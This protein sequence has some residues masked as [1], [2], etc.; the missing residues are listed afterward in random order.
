MSTHY[1]SRRM[2]VTFS[3]AP[4]NAL[5][6]YTRPADRSPSSLLQ[7]VRRKDKDTKRVVEHLQSSFGR[8]HVQPIPVVARK[9]GFVNTV[10]EA[11][12]NHHAL[13]IRPDDVWICIL[14]QFS[15]FV[16]G[17]DRA[18]KLRH[19]FVAHE[20]KKELTV[21]ADGDRYSVDFRHLAQ[22][23]TGQIHKNVV[24]PELRSW[25][26]PDFSTTTA[27]DTVVASV[28][29][30]ATLKAYFDYRMVLGCGLPRVTLLGTQEDWTSIFDRVD[31]LARYG[32]E[33][34]AWRD[35]LKPVLARFAKA[36][37]PGYA[38]S[39][40]NLDFWQRVA[41]RHNGGSGP[42]YLSGWITAFCAFDKEGR[43][44][45]GSNSEVLKKYQATLPFETADAP[46]LPAG[47]EASS[48]LAKYT[49][50]HI[51]AEEHNWLG[52]TLCIDGVQYHVMD[53]DDI[54]IAH[55]EV[56]VKLND[57]GAEFETVMFAGLVGM[58]LGDVQMENEQVVKNAEL[59]PVAAW[60]MFIA[61]D[62]KPEEIH[63]DSD[64]LG[65]WLP[66]SHVEQS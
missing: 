37:E 36:F 15:L 26:L 21:Y 40:E 7:A 41:H 60:W 22:Q 24:D 43:W 64:S 47:P 10:I 1:H 25:I 38:E 2:P 34:A 12:N 52:Q 4:H 33:T 27:N 20:G 46:A 30:M 5:E 16:N 62:P 35:L 65:A 23:M 44:V 54:P 50:G 31:R 42:S 3:P 61:G 28:V 45:G 66:R 63:S 51:I 32:P 59:S 58:S 57:N 39:Q 17:G 18:E 19:L 9:N 48:T 14:T 53:A 13:V 56:D 29:M 6:S 49:F 8:D 55:A 11:Y